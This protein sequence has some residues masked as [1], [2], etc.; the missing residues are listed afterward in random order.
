M[1][2][3][4]GLPKS[5]SEGPE[6]MSSEAKDT[7]V[8][9]HCQGFCCRSCGHGDDR[10]CCDECLQELSSQMAEDWSTI[11]PLAPSFPLF[12]SSPLLLPTTCL[13][14]HLGKKGST[15][16]REGPRAGLAGDGDC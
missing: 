4:G 8:N 10:G 2:Y 13:L 6:E 11:Y 15:D 3:L 12:D 16:F 7:N 9:V 5:G 14:L 1:F